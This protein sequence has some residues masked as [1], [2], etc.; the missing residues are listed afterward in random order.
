MIKSLK[1]RILLQYKLDIPVSLKVD[2]CPNDDNSVKILFY[3][4][5]VWYLNNFMF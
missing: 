3:P 5:Y 4:F 2:S 1:S